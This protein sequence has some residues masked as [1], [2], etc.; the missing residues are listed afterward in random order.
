MIIS[1]DTYNDLI[2]AFSYKLTLESSFYWKKA[3]NR[4]VEVFILDYA[5]ISDTD[6][7][8]N[9][10][11]DT[12][13]EQEVKEAIIASEENSDTHL[14]IPRLSVDERIEIMKHFIQI[15]TDLNQKQSL[16]NTLTTLI[17]L[18]KAKP[19]DLIKNGFEMGFDFN[20]LTKNTKE[21]TDSWIVFY[22][23]Q[24]KPFVD[25]WLTAIKNNNLV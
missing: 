17:N 24:T 5:L 7:D 21:L 23:S 4:L 8:Y 2:T 14:F 1:E 11:L 15:Q 16:E 13:E 10:G 3:T 19:I 9:S 22:R 18:K 12:E 20:N 25:K 6:E